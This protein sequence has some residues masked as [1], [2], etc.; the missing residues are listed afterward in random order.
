MKHVPL[1]RLPR[2]AWPLK[3]GTPLIA[4]A[5]IFLGCDDRNEVKTA[6]AAPTTQTMKAFPSRLIRLGFQTPRQHD[7]GDYRAQVIVLVR[8]KTG[9][10]VLPRVD[11]EEPK[12]GFADRIYYE[13][14]RQAPLVA[15]GEG[16]AIGVPDTPEVDRMIFL[17][18]SLSEETGWRYLEIDR[19]AVV[20][21]PGGKVMV[22]NLFGLELLDR[23]DDARDLW[24]LYEQAVANP[25]RR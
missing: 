10:M 15:V 9:K 1:I 12:R 4:L 25:K 3:V 18:K 16:S 20:D 22:P 21:A 11:V 23:R 24:L 19:K 17:I 7:Q 14:E 13:K 5:G 6:A 8:L 2:K